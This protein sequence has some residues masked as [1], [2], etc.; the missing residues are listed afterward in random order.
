MTSMKNKFSKIR[1][2]TLCYLIAF[3]LCIVLLLWGVTG[4]FSTV[5]YEKY[6]IRDIEKIA[7]E[8]RRK[9]VK[10]LDRYLTDV[11]YDN[12]VCIEYI[13]KKG[14]TLYNDAS[15]GCMLGRRNDVL[16]KYKTEIIESGK[17]RKG[18]KIVNPEFKTS[19]LIYGVKI[20]TGY[21]FLFTMLSNINKN[22]EIIRVRLFYI[23]ILIIILA[24]VLGSYLA[25]MYTEPIVKISTKAKEL[26]KGNFDVNFEKAGIVEVDELVDSLNYMKTE[27]SKTD[28]YRRDLIAN[29]SHDLKTP[30]T[31]IKAYA[32]MVRDIT[33]DDKEKREAN[34]NVIIDEA[35]R[36][37]VLVGD[38]LSYTKMQ[39]NRDTLVMEKFDLKVELDNIL[40]KYDYLVES[41]GYKFDLI[42]PEEMIVLA[43]KNKL[44]QVIYNLLNNAI[45]YTGK[46]KLVTIR[47]TENKDNYLVEIIDTGKG[48]DKKE[49]DHI[50]DKYY[51]SDKK[52]KRNVYGT[53]LGLSIVKE[54]LMKHNF[55]YGVE[56][57]KGKGSNFYFYVDKYVVKK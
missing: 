47:I 26:A 29:V 13:S 57:T 49:I 8:I 53:G 23:T 40:K 34:L 51:K 22:N 42:A 27:V 35:D 37:N 25:K 6:Q 9:D 45:N 30:L 32:E 12:E 52:Y 21:V 5:L 14:V 24:V 38:I 28:Q 11:V 50:W 3:A 1:V 19:A 36:L 2:R 18:I 16:R 41:E 10:D 55:K 20:D 43:D 15:T 39:A 54:I 17:T 4:F 7:K 33:Y 31:M 46:D 48:I 44:N 56:S